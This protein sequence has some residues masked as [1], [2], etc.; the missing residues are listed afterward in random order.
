MQFNFK[1]LLTALMKS[2]YRRFATVKHETNMFLIPH[3]LHLLA[4]FIMLFVTAWIIELSF[5]T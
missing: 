4:I 1:A 2:E 3:F 5:R